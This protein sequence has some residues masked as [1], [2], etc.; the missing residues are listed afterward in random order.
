MNT[1]KIG[2]FL[3]GMALYGAGVS[4]V[5]NNFIL[6]CLLGITGWILLFIED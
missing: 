5:Y 3:G 6:F 1:N 2:I 4:S